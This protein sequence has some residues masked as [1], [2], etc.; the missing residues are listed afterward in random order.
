[1]GL[2]NQ[3]MFEYSVKKGTALTFLGEYCSERIECF[4]AKQQFSFQNHMVHKHAKNNKANQCKTCKE[5]LKSLSDV[6]EHDLKEHQDKQV[7]HD[8]S[9]VFSESM[10]D[11]FD[12]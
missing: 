1:M 3:K 2:Q 10:L 12:L 5:N 7:Q 4:A 8:I 9:F 6:L 11:E